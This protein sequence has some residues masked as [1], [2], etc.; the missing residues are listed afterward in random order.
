MERTGCASGAGQ[1]AGSRHRGRPTCVG[2]RFEWRE[3]TQSGDRREGSCA[4]G[5]RSRSP[6][7]TPS[8]DTPCGGRW[9]PGRDCLLLGCQADT[10][11]SRLPPRPG[12]WPQ[13]WRRNGCSLPGPFHAARVRASHHRPFPLQLAV[14]VLVASSPGPGGTLEG[15]VG[16]LPPALLHRLSLGPISPA[17]LLG[18]PQGQGAEAAPGEGTTSCRPTVPSVGSRTDFPNSGVARSARQAAWVG[19]GQACP[20]QG[21]HVCPHFYSSWLLLLAWPSEPVPRSSRGQRHLG[22][23]K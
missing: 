1:L 12:C 7:P 3:R 18:G 15:R 14:E 21:G 11:H 23:G 5:W 20:Q 22:G 9:L 17:E 10:G 19:R 4:R 2:R 16:S 13:P 6:L 8:P